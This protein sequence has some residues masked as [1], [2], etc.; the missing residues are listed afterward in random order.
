MRAKLF[1]WPVVLLMCATL[2]LAPYTPAP[3]I[4]EDLKWIAG[5]AHDMGA[6]NWLDFI[7]HG[8]PWVL[9]LGLTIKGIIGVIK[10]RNVT[11]VT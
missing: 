3:H 4:W 7:M 5:G 1:T 2:G 10:Q 11:K 6:M 9:L 8:T